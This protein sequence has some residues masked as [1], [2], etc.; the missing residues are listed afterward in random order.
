MRFYIFFR[1]FQYWVIF[2]TMLFLINKCLDVSFTPN[3]VSFLFSKNASHNDATMNHVICILLV[4]CYPFLYQ[5]YKRLPLICFYINFSS[6]QNNGTLQINGR[7]KNISNFLISGV[8]NL[9]N[10]RNIFYLAVNILITP[11][12]PK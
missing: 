10:L 6:L 8:N 11:L 5:Q 2:F 9:H 1:V 7:R 3:L 12:E 4:I